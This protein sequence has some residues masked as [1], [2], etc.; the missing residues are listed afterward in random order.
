MRT[1]VTII[2]EQN[3]DLGHVAATLRTIAD[4]LESARITKGDDVRRRSENGSV[5]VV[6]DDG[7]TPRTGTQEVLIDPDPF[8]QPRPDAG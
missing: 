4:D 7:A 3:D 5:R 6:L 2:N 8:V 1:R